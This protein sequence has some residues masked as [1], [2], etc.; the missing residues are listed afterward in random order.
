MFSR[1]FDQWPEP[2][3]LSDV[4]GIMNRAATEDVSSSLWPV[5][6]QVLA[7]GEAPFVPPDARLD[8][9]MATFAETAMGCVAVVSPG[10][11]ALL[12]IITEGDLRRAYAPDLFDKTA[13]DIMTRDPMTLSPQALIRQ[14][15][16][17]MKTRRIAHLA[18]VEDGRAV[19]ILHIKDLMQH[20]F[21]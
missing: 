16:E 12:G 9:V 1:N 19:N 8:R 20:G 21:A 10:D 14:A 3:A 5:I 13:A 18:V 11:G 7:A 15:V 2:A 4:V 6:S 17:L